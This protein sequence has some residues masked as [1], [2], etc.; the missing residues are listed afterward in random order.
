MNQDKMKKKTIF[1][2]SNYFQQGKV[3]T[4]GLKQTKRSGDLLKKDEVVKKKDKT[5]IEKV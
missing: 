4:K 5:D 2:E 1:L 3:K